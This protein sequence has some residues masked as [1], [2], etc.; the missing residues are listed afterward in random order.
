MDSLLHR[1]GLALS[2]MNPLD[3][4]IAVTLAV[5]TV[6]A[7]VRGLILS[8]ISL[9]GLLAGVFAATLYAPRVSPYLLRWTGV[10]PFARIAAFL[11]I[12]LAVYLVAALLGRLLRG[13]FSAVGLGFLDRLGGAVFGFARGALLLAALLLPL[14]P[15]LQQFTAARSSVLLPYLLPAAHGISFVLPRHLAVTHRP[16]D[17]LT[18]VLWLD[19]IR[20]STR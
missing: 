3:W 12:L 20:A 6:T 17:P 15:Y 18:R 11:L 8:V 13:A 9:A 14:F 1:T 16:V 7:F 5:S 4:V 19:G 10:A 2:G